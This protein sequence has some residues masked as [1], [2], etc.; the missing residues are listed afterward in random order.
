MTI[1][2]I[3]KRAIGREA[4]FTKSLR[5]IYSGA[6]RGRFEVGGAEE[7]DADEE[8]EDEDAEDEEAED[9]EDDEAVKLAPVPP[10]A[11]TK[12]STFARLLSISLAVNQFFLTL[13]PFSN[14]NSGA[15][16]SWP[17]SQITWTISFSPRFRARDGLRSILP[18]SPIP[19]TVGGASIPGSFLVSY[20]RYSDF[21]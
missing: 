4:S 2:I 16:G 19:E 7:E 9:E 12:R 15:N 10:G 18:M 11:L 17:I 1:A 21:P 20:K 8:D 14:T 5:P 6:C 13:S 3:Q